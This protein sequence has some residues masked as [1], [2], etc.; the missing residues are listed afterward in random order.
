MEG[1]VRF[2]PKLCKIGYAVVAHFVSED[3]DEDNYENETI[4]YNVAEQN[5]KNA[6]LS[7]LV[8]GSIISACMQMEITFHSY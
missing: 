7:S 2:N 4:S 5:K 1:L 3:E 6:F 8:V